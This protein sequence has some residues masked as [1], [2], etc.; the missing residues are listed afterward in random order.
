VYVFTRSGVSWSQQAKLLAADKDDYETFGISVALSGDGNTALIGAYF[1]SSGTNRNGAAYVF[2]RSMGGWSQQQKL[3]ADDRASQDYFGL[4]VA[5]SGDGNT[6]LIGAA[7]SSDNNT[8][9]NGAAYVFTRSMGGWSQ[10]Q[11]L[12][13]VDMESFN[14]FGVAVALSGDGNVALIGAPYESDSGTRHNGAAYVFTRSMGGWSQQQKLLAGDKEEND[15]LGWSVALSK[16]GN[17]ALGGALGES[18]SGTYGNGAV[19]VFT[20]SMG[21]WSQQSKLLAAD[22]TTGDG[23]G[24]SV[25]LSGDGNA[26]LAGAPYEDD[27][28]AVNNGA[29]YLFI[30]PPPPT[31]TPTATPIP[32]RPDTI[33]IYHNGT[34]YLRN[35]N[36]T[37][38]PDVTASFGGDPS[39]LPVVG[40][41][42]G[43]GMDT[44]GVYRNSTGFFLLSNSNT[45]PVVSYAVLLG[46]PGDTPFAG[47][48]RSDMLGDGI[49]VFRP[50]NGILY[51][52]RDL[53]SGFS[54]Y[55]A[56]FGNPSDVAFAGDWNGDGLDSIGVYRAATGRWYMTQNSQPTGITYS[57]HSFFWNVGN[58]VPIIGDWDG[59][60]VSTVGYRVSTTFVLHDTLEST[61]YDTGFS[62]GASAGRPV[63]GKWTLPSQPPLSRVV[64]PI[65][66]NPVSG[67][68]DGTD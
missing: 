56:I 28:G 10:Q 22:K 40:D 43:D 67:G 53:T 42:N 8:T 12:L 45:T 37:G 3:L 21:N 66:G 11:K 33:G 9:E 30:N 61:G 62:F 48:W 17:T 49:G 60:R 38:S 6:A 14:Y 47:K 13:A 58:A 36:S 57:D 52:K 35:T 32:A 5:L 25:A 64:Q 20:R 63:V 59:N 23:L 68:S 19:Y 2:T 51:Q 34:W 65:S 31:P 18:D 15:Y 7:Y 54:D 1:E 46:N 27:S 4:P 26:A 24:W 29:A 16:D 55:F 50:S 39:D 44:L 41:W